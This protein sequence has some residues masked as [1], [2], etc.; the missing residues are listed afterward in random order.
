MTFNEIVTWLWANHVKIATE[1]SQLFW[2]TYT[3]VL[4]QVCPNGIPAPWSTICVITAT[5]LTFYGFQ[6]SATVQATK[7]AIAKSC[8]FAFRA[9]P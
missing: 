3:L 7:T 1:L 2:V 4:P 6:N 5:L 9:K 8:S